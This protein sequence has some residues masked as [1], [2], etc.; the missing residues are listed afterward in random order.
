MSNVSE[1]KDDAFTAALEKG[2]LPRSSSSVEA[3]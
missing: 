3:T 1:T 2:V